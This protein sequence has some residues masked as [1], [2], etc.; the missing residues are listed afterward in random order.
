M[1]S[2]PPG[3]PSSSS[4]SSNYERRDFC[5]QSLLMILAMTFSGATRK[6]MDERLVERFGGPSFEKSLNPYKSRLLK[7]SWGV[8]KASLSGNE[9]E[10][11]M[12]FVSDFK[13]VQWTEAERV[14]II[15]FG[16][17]WAEHHRNKQL[18]QP[19]P[20]PTT[21]SSPPSS[22][23]TTTTE[24]VSRK[25]TSLSSATTTPM[26]FQAPQTK[27]LQTLD[28]CR[29][30]LQRRVQ[31]HRNWLK[32]QEVSVQPR[33]APY[34]YLLSAAYTPQASHQPSPLFQFHY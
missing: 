17:L 7:F 24:R 28:T 30:A 31:W 32:Q 15:E 6:V 5:S 16:R 19:P 1:P 21:S 13:S 2:T 4:S 18:L 27:R 34:L 9:H 33:L 23:T 22:M 11:R 3:S 25:R 20:P 10:L 12:S 8:Y 26:T 14:Q 29:Q